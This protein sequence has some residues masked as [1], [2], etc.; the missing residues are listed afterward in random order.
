MTRDV[1]DYY[2]PVL[3]P[4][5][6]VAVV[7]FGFKPVPIGV[8]SVDRDGFRAAHSGLGSPWQVKD[9]I[10]GPAIRSPSVDLNAMCATL[11]A[12][13]WIDLQLRWE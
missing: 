13:W 3:G 10:V 11:Y 12:M 7:G 4:E 8:G 9:R 6:H 5:R 2:T 1:P